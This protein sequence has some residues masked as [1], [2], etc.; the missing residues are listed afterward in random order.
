MTP[1]QF[2]AMMQMFARNLQ[3]AQPKPTNALVKPR[4]GG[5]DSTG[6]WTGEGINGSPKSFNCMRAFHGG[7]PLKT[8]TA[9]KSIET[10]CT[11][12]LDAALQFSLKDEPNGCSFVQSFKAFHDLVVLTGTDGVFTIILDDG[13]TTYNMFLDAGMISATMVTDWIDKLL[14]DGVLLATNG[15]PTRLQICSHDATNCRWSAEALFNSC[16]EALK[17]EIRNTV[18][19]TKW[20]GPW[21]LWVLLQKLYRPSYTSIESL[22]QQLS[23]LNIRD[24]PAQDVGKYVA[25]ALLIIREIDLNTMRRGSMPELTMLALKGLMD[26]EDDFFRSMVKRIRL[27]SDVNGHGSGIGNSNAD[28]KETLATLREK[29]RILVEQKSYDPAL[30]STPAASA[31]VGKSSALATLQA[32]VGQAV[33]A[34]VGAMKQDRSASGSSGGGSQTSSSSGNSSA[35]KSVTFATPLDDATFAKLNQLI[36]DKL[37]TLPVRATI[38]D[39]AE[40]N[41]AIDGVI[42][43]KYCKH[44]GRFIKGLK[45][46]Y[47]KDHSGTWK[48]PYKPHEKAN[49]E[50]ATAPGTVTREGNLASMVGA[51]TPEECVPCPP[52]DPTLSDEQGSPNVHVPTVDTNSFL[53]GPVSYAFGETIQVDGDVSASD[54]DALARFFGL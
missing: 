53:T 6:A 10:E 49:S 42:L 22:K 12:G 44:C 36:K 18:P 23:S 26:C 33:E 29:H 8:F 34:K 15:Q 51:L 35:K 4:S 39:D 50:G 3:P 48:R 17:E 30:K 54:A 5:I 37:A 24:Y 9:L 52:F 32:M 2:N 1:D 14:N 11:K 16:S 20:N 41:V 47:T 38:P 43:A 40:Y 45:A 31:L 28:P 13:V 27:D 19:A 46:H 21:L 7:D 25:D